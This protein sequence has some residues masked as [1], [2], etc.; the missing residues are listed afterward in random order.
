MA[1][2]TKLA[3]VPQE[4]VLLFRQDHRQSLKASRIVECSHLIAYS[5]TVQPLGQV[6]G[7]AIDGGEPLDVGLWHPLRPP[8]IHGSESVR[9]IW[10]ELVAA[11]GPYSKVE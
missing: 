1:Y 2:S 4:R 7:K 6:L 9:M 5:V 10:T 3:S 8:L 11:W